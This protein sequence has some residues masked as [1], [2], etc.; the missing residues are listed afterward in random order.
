MTRSGPILTPYW[1]TKNKNGSDITFYN[2]DC[3]SGMDELIT[4]ESLDVVVTSPPYNIGI[5]YSEHEDNLPRNEYLKWMEKFA[6]SVKRVL[7][8]DGS[9]FL[10]VGNIPK[11][12]WIA[13]D[14][15]NSMRKHLALQNVIHWVKSI[16]ITKEY[17]GSKHNLT[18]DLSFGHYKPIVSKRFL[19]DSHEFVFH[20]TKEGNSNLDK[21]SI[22][23]PYQDKS[24]VSRWKNT[25]GDK[26][27]RGN[28][29]FLPY[30][31][32]T[33]RAERPHPASFP[34]KLPEMCIRLHGIDKDLM[35]MDPF[36]GIGSTAVAAAALGVSFVGFD[37][38]SSYLE[39]AK[40]R[41]DSKIQGR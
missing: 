22:G 30:D 5:N 16:S 11:D 36:M 13:W 27:D 17:A 1:E 19:N 23:V 14:V 33:K 8:E 32:I 29:W 34:V 28:V 12:P 10:N 38:D 6:I 37:I 39:E 4:E 18:E 24:N 3:V 20:F 41:V 31:T 2:T 35:V 21:L 7:K 26:R 15:A 9:F 40:G 25:N